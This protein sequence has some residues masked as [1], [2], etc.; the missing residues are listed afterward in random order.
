MWLRFDAD[1][2]GEIDHEETIGIIE[3]ILDGKVTPK[4]LQCI[5]VNIINMIT[6]HLISS[7][8][9]RSREMPQQ[10]PRGW[11]VSRGLFIF[12]IFFLFFNFPSHVS[13]STSFQFAQ[14]FFLEGELIARIDTDGNGTLDEQEFLTVSQSFISP[15]RTIAITKTVSPGL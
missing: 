15:W 8:I 4:T 3:C 2:S 6:R 9:F 7:W 14:F 13:S 10:L 11:R 12:S 1:H 5:E